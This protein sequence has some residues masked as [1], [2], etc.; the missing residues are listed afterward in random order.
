M[1]KNESRLIGEFDKNSVEVVRIHIQEFRAMNYFD[2]RVWASATGEDK[3]AEKPTH[4]GLTL[5]VELLPQ[6]IELLRKAQAAM[7]GE[8][9]ETA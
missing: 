6:L 7:E 8:D 2:I 3:G 9:G 4:K 1:N 5:N